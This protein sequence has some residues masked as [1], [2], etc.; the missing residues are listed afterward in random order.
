[1]SDPVVSGFIGRSV[2]RREDH[3][4]LTG[5]GVFVADLQLPGML[6]AAIVRSPHAHA[7]IVG[8]DTTAAAA[9]PGV[10]AVVTSADVVKA[11]GPVPEQQVAIPNRWKQSVSH[12]FKSPRQPILA[13]DKARHAGEAMA[14][15]VARDRYTAED[16]AGLV[17]ADLGPLPVVVDVE[18]ALASGAPLVH[19]E[20]GTNVISEYRVGKGDV[21]ATFREAPRTLA[22]RFHH[23]RYTGTPMECRGVVADW[24]GRTQSLT[25]WASTQVVHWVKRQVATLLGIAESRVR[26]VAPDVGGGFGIKGHVYPEDVLLAYLAWSLGRPVKWIEDRREHFLASIHSRDQVHEAEVAFDDTG[27]ILAVRDRFALDCGAWNP[28]GAGLAY[29]TAAHL[30]GPYKVDHYFME[31]RVVCTNKVPNAPYRGAGR[32]EAVFAMER[33]VDLIAREVGR[34]PAEV[35]QRNMVA[36]HEMPYAVGIPYRDG[37]PIVYDSGDFP[38]AFQRALEA[39]GGLEAFRERQRAARAR[40]RYLGLGFGCYTEGT[41]AGPF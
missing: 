10:V 29:N 22:R 13:V 5:R 40:G 14:V 24:D 32:P 19:E 28:I 35:R 38:R 21:E 15:V 25:V 23:H 8:V 11:L 9:V 33:L 2:L 6:H 26:C 16:A 41:G 18:Q 27:R 34:E 3:R 36:A 7:R 39:V 37:V 1:M 12:S 17:R 4:L 20:F 31:G 30:L